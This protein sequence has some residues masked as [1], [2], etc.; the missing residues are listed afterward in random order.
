MAKAQSSMEYLLVLAGAMAALLVILPA[1]GFAVKTVFFS[2]DCIAAADFASRMQS[3]VNTAEF[4]SNGTRIGV[5]ARPLGTW[6]M[7]AEGKSLKLAVLKDD[8]E[9][10]FEIKIPSSASIDFS[11]SEKK[12]FAVQ[13]ENNRLLIEHD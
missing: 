6:R 7:A 4:L 12:V 8:L 11:F 9:K 10:K 3:A 13:K 5:V 2:I 1:I